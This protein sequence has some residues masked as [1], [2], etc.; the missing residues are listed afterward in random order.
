MLAAAGLAVSGVFPRFY[1]TTPEVRAL[2]AA[3]HFDTANKAA[4]ARNLNSITT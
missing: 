4:D 1:N 3:N 2:A